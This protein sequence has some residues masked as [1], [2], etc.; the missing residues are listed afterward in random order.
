MAADGA[1]TRII[2]RASRE[3]PS[4]GILVAG[5]LTVPC[6]LGRSGVTRHKREGDGATPAGP[7]RFVSSHYRHDRAPR[8]ATRL[9][10][11][12]QSAPSGWCDDPL[13]RNYNRPVTL[14]Y[15]ASHERLWRDDHLYDILVVLDWNLWNPIAYRGSAIFFHIAAP[16]FAPTAGCVAVTLPAMR[17]ILALSG[18]ETYLDV[19]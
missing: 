13:D 9:A 1:L 15:P 2:V 18:P 3:N 11:S 16:D 4:R 10:V 17:K 19:G 14:P 12:R 5:T 6:A 7:L 8:P